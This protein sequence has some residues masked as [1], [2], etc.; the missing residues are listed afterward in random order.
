MGESSAE[1]SLTFSSPSQR[2]KPVLHLQAQP[3]RAVPG[4]RRRAHCASPRVRASERKED[5]RTES[6]LRAHLRRALFLF[7]S[8][9]GAFYK[10]T[11]PPLLNLRKYFSHLFLP[12]GL[13]SFAFCDIIPSI[14][15]EAEGCRFAGPV[16][17]RGIS[18]EYVRF[19]RAS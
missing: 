8:F 12:E 3:R 13:I 18:V 17:G 16:G 11:P 19:N 15:D 4:D 10:N 6:F 5:E 1:L 14:C 9:F 2:R 7:P